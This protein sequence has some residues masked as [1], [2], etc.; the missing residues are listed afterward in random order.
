MINI[1]ETS[2]E[3]QRDGDWRIA[4]AGV[5]W[6]A[7]G[8]YVRIGAGAR[9]GDEARIGD[10]ASIGARASIGDG[11][12]IGAR[13]S[14]GDGARIGDGASIGAR[15]SIGDGASIGAA[16]TD[17]TDLGVTD[18]YRKCLYYVKGKPYIGAGCRQLTLEQARAH[19]SNHPEDRRAT[20]LQVAMAEGLHALRQP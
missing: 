11:A 13:A 19:W 17:V 15:A 2:R 9:I 7:E 5:T 10:G 18:G 1:E 12:S 6:C 20:M 14:I 3:W 4:P 8:N 16:A